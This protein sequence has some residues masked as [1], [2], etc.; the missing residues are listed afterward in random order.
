LYQVLTLRNYFYYQYFNQI[1][2]VSLFVWVINRDKDLIGEKWK[3]T[4]EQIKT[5]FFEFYHYS[6]PLFIDSSVAL[7]AAFGD[8]WL[9]QKFAGSI[10]QGF[11]GLSYNIGALCF[12]F[13][14]AMTPLLMREYSIAFAGKDLKKMAALFRRYVPMLYSL[15]AF[16]SC[17]I[18]MQSDKVIYILGG[19]G[20]KTANVAVKIMA[21]YPLHQ[22]YGQLSSAVLLAAGK[23]KIF[24]N[25]GVFVS[26]IGLIITFFLIAPQRFMGLNA[27]ATGLAI[28]MVF[29]QVVVVNIYL[30][31]NSKFLNISFWRYLAHQAGSFGL[32][33][34]ISAGITF[35]TG[36][37]ALLKGNI[38]NFFV[39]GFFYTASVIWITYRFPVIF[40]LK[41]NDIVFAK[42]FIRK[43]LVMIRGN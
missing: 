22:T 16:F 41:H 13:T 3:L 31:F 5:Y 10:Q 11:Y 43:K 20:Y 6:F 2:L 15:S 36:N 29:V 39:S 14:G 1:L 28:K 25:V 24:R 42:E 4:L 7:L 33:L 40:G 34:L 38:V 35:I 37:I 21:L 32:L 27:G 18:L 12:L 26:V 9:L 23:T 30:F 19:S 17:F 8:R